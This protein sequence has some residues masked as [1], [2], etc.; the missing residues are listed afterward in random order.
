M[1]DS[2]IIKQELFFEILFDPLELEALTSFLTVRFVAKA[3]S[4]KSLNPS[5]KTDGKGS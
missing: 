2:K 4:F 1:I 3:T 5:V